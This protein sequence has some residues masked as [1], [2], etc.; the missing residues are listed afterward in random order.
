M[1]E[2]TKHEY[3]IEFGYVY[4]LGDS[5]VWDTITVWEQL[6]KEEVEEYQDSTNALLAF[7]PYKLFAGT[8]FINLVHVFVLGWSL[9]EEEF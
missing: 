2:A 5:K 9:A 8:N 3:A 7:F 6:T 1:D 4:F